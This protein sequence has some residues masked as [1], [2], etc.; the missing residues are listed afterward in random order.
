MVIAAVVS[1]IVIAFIWPT[2]TSSA[3]HIPIAV[4]GPAVQVAAIEKGLDGAS[5]DVLDPHTVDDRSA[6]VRDI[7]TRDVYGAI[8]LDSGTPEVLTAS[9]AS[10]A[11][12]QTLH[13][14]ATTLQQQAQSAAAKQATAAGT[15]VPTVTVKV[16]DVVPLSKDD[17]NGSGL[18]AAAFPLVMGGML[19]GIILTFLIHGTGR[20]LIG[21]AVYGIV[22]GLAVPAILQGW[23]GIL[24]GPYLVNAA[25]FALSLSAIAG[26]ILGAAALVGRAGIAVGPVVFLLFA[27]PLSSAAT[28]VEFLPEPWGAVGQWFPPGAGARLIRDISYFPD[29]N[30]TLQWLILAGWTALGIALTGL[31][32]VLHRRRL[33]AHHGEHVARPDH[34]HALDPLTV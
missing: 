22:G 3:K 6:A 27:N 8:V 5:G 11:V 26:T 24:Q 32:A 30:N 28:P 19:G 15:A 16:T 14:L 34:E 21:L 10:P 20:R 18:A 31:A 17:A 1:L 13:T 4:S 9:A 33:N 25:A 7:K 29:A 12:S 2:V 23:F